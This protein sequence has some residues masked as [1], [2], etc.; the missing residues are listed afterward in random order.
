[1]EVPGLADVGD[2]GV[3]LQPEGPEQKSVLTTLISMKNLRG[4]KGNLYI[5][6]KENLRK[7]Q[8]LWIHVL[9]AVGHLGRGRRALWTDLFM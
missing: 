1:M 7:F 9:K 5:H 2:R 4:R 8:N 6:I 3:E